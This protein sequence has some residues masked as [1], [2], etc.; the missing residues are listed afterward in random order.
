MYKSNE[1]IKFN[2]NPWKIKFINLGRKGEI[3]YVKK[4]FCADQ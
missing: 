4:M 2:K 1:I 3:F